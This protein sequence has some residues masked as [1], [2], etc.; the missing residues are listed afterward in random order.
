M[1]L[2]AAKNV[3]ENGKENNLIQLISQNE[4]FKPVWEQLSTILDKKN[5]IGRSVSQTEEFINKP[6]KS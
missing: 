2:V 6:V 4:K 1:S 3:K 5:F